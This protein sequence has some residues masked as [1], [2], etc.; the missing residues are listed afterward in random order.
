MKN[1]NSNK[2]LLLWYAHPRIAIA[3]VLI[4]INLLII[5]SFTTALSIISGNPF[6]DELAYIFAFTMSSDGIYDFVTGGADDVICFVLKIVLALIQMVI[7]SGALIGFTTDVLQN[8]FDNQLSNKNKMHLKNHY[9]FLNW[10]TIGQNII[11]DLSFLDGEKTIVILAEEDREEIQTS[12]DNI[13][14]AMKRKKTGLRIFVKKGDPTSSKHLADISISKA[15]HVGIL[16][17]N[18]E[19]DGDDAISTKDLTSFKLLLT[20][21]GEAPNAN[22]VVETEHEIAKEKIEQLMRSAHPEAVSRVAVFSHNAVMG[23]VLGRTVIDP[24]YSYL[25]HQILSFEGVEFYGIPTM[26][27]EEALLT[28]NDCIPIVNY[29]DDDEVDADGKKRADQLYILSDTEDT[30]GVRDEKRSFAKPIKYREHLEAP[31]F[32]LFIFSDSDRSE[33]VISELENSNRF[34]GANIRYRV[35]SYK[36]DL[37]KAIKTVEKTEGVRKIL[38]LSEEEYNTDNQDSAVFLSLLELKQSKI[39]CNEVEL[40]VEIVNV[41]NLTPVKNLETASVILSNKIISLYMLQLLTHNGSHKFFKDVLLSNSE[42]GEID[43]EIDAARELLEFDEDSMTFSCC[44]EVVQS[45]YF[46]SGKRRMLVGYFPAEA[47][48]GE[49]QY[50]CDKMDEERPVVIKP[51]DKLITVTYRK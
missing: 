33:F 37:E 41:D 18:K 35:F 4:A 51:E 24:D 45:F 23:H 11:Y 10:S 29:D 6:F 44:S 34:G 25:F 40:F 5:F 13:F 7:F 16:L 1:K 43:F 17:S 47:K 50:F 49:A 20:M 28:Y 42:M 39:I 30:L 12:I 3:L 36:D 46:A 38:L 15:S 32:T 2:L 27:I 8:T 14:T 9:V 22:I 21:L 26:D 31:N 48:D 19:S